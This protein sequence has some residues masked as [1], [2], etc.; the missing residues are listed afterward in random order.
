MLRHGSY[1]VDPMR[2]L[3][4]IAA[5]AASMT[6]AGGIA[7]GARAHASLCT[8]REILIQVD[9]L[10]KLLPTPEDTPRRQVQMGNLRSRWN[11]MWNNVTRGNTVN[12][13][14][15]VYVPLL[16]TEIAQLRASVEALM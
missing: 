10:L 16:Q 13:S 1:V 11:I 5:T 12:P 3:M 15:L 2:A 9:V 4:A 14:S 6:V 8:L 7:A